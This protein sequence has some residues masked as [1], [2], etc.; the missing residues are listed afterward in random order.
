MKII[1]KNIM[2]SFRK[3]A[4]YSSPQN[5]IKTNQ[6]VIGHIYGSKTYNEN[7][8]YSINIDKHICDDL[9]HIYF[10]KS[11]IN[12]FKFHSKIGIIITV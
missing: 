10:S 3:H 5:N 7:I 4:R 12:I 1:F 8:N 6:V 2:T 9:L 11:V